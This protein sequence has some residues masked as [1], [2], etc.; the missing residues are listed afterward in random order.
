MFVPVFIFV[1]VTRMLTASGGRRSA[2]GVSNSQSHSRSLSSLNS[3]SLGRGANSNGSLHPL[4][5][6][7]SGGGRTGWVSN[8]NRSQ[9]RHTSNDAA[10]MESVSNDRPTDTMGR[11]WDGM[12]ESGTG[13]LSCGS[14]SGTSSSIG[15]MMQARGKMFKQSQLIAR[16]VGFRPDSALPSHFHLYDTQP[17]LRPRTS[18]TRGS[19]FAGVCF[20]HRSPISQIHAHRDRVAT[21]RKR[22]GRLEVQKEKGHRM[23]VE[24]G[25][26]LRPIA[27]F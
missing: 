19:G 8:W 7:G 22:L 16:Q 11:H 21:A 14:F 9:D 18:P 13:P 23:Q 6:G 3:N 5:Y 12:L 2:S 20:K 4:Q 25:A 15:S 24:L 1:Q 17:S 10:D 26:D 27:S